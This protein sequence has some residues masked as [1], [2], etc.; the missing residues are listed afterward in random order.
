MKNKEKWKLLISGLVIL[1]PAAAGCILWRRLPDTLATHWGPDGI[2]D[3]FSGKAFAVFG[4]PLVMLFAQVLTVLLVEK[5]NGEKQDR[6][7]LDVIYWILPAVSVMVCSVTYGSAMGKTTGFTTLLPLVFSFLFILIGN[8]LPKAKRNRTLGVKVK[9]TLV[10]DENWRRTH[11]FT[12]KLWFYSGLLSLCLLLLPE[13]AAETAFTVLLLFLVFLPFLYSFLYYRKQKREGTWTEDNTVV[14]PKNAKTGAVF[15]LLI[16]LATGI[17]MFSGD[18]HIEYG[19]KGF[20]VDSVYWHPL[21]VDYKAIDTIELRDDVETGIRTH[22]FGSARLMMGT[23]RNDEFG[24]YERYAYTRNRECIVIESGGK[25][26]VLSGKDGEETGR[27]YRTILEKTE[28]NK[29]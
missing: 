10:N 16:L 3:G 29:Y 23:F 20:T 24:T 1:S 5:D 4:L 11:R 22:G 28:A 13:K 9:W 21:T 19:E 2:A 12:G 18:I 17:L 26:L 14:S 25:I 15:A 6:K 8:Y 7:I 27:I